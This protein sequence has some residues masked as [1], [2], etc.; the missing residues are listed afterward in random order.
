MKI[1]IITNVLKIIAVLL[2]SAP[3]GLM[4]TLYMS[5]IWRW[6]ESSF[7]IESIGHSGPATW[8]YLL[9]YILCVVAGYSLLIL[10]KKNTNDNQEQRSSW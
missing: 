10:N 9:I 1:S 4:L 5:P 8:C 2:V 6:I 7:G 3:L